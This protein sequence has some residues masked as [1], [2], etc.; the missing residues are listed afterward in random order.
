VVQGTRR[1]KGVDVELSTSTRESQ[2]DVEAEKSLKG[3][4]D[5]KKKRGVHREFTSKGGGEKT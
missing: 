5:L 3:Q 2:R 4:T 1:S